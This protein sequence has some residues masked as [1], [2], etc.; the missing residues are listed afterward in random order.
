MNILKVL[1]LVIAAMSFSGAATAAVVDN[2]SVTVLGTSS[3]AYAGYDRAFALDTGPGRY[4][5]DFAGLNTGV[6]THLDFAFSAPTTFSQIVYTDRTSSGGAN[7]SNSFGV[8]DYVNKYKYEFANDALFNDIVGTYTSQT[9]NAPVAPGSYLAFQHTDFIAGFT[10]QF[11]RF[12]VL[13]T[14][15]N[16]PGASNFEFIGDV[17]AV[18]EPGTAA[19]LGLG[20]LGFAASRRK[21]AKK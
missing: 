10:A 8:S 6:G 14:T 15:G 21:S 13:E 3:V 20:L 19:L 11:V 18:P 12:T 5:A 17:N 4:S 7:N 9:S 16:N 1:P 2:A